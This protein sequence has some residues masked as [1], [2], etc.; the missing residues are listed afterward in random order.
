MFI[1]QHLE[2]DRS[3]T[4]PLATFNMTLANMKMSLFYTMEDYCGSRGGHENRGYQGDNF[5]F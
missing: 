5:F 4:S 3:P 1:F 2:N